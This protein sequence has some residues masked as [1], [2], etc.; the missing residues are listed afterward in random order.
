M[1]A[2]DNSLIS[3][4]YFNKTFHLPQKVCQKHSQCDNRIIEGMPGKFTVD[5]EK[6]SICKRR[7]ARK[8]IKL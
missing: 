7:S 2:F 3:Q 4:K 8:S 5:I 6:Q 1:K